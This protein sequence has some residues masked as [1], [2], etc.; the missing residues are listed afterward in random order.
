MDGS[1]AE[2]EVPMDVKEGGVEVLSAM[3]VSAEDQRLMFVKF[4]GMFDQETRRGYMAD[5]NEN[6]DDPELR[7][8]FLQRMTDDLDDH[9]AFIRE[10]GTKALASVDP[11][12]RQKIFV[13]LLSKHTKE[14][15][16]SMILE[17]MTVKNNPDT[18]EEFLQGMY[19]TLMDDDDFIAMEGKKAFTELRILEE[20][21]SAIFAKFMSVTTGE[22]RA[23]YAAGYR[24]AR[25]SPSQKKRFL[26]KLIGLIDADDT[27]DVSFSQELISAFVT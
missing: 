6:K 11:D 13:A 26:E 10:Q 18:K 21:Q 19:E 9:E 5:W 7:V 12:V 17:W 22:D 23:A 2:V 14:E 1:G 15:R 16:E 25:L 20:D 27:T 4:M 8:A 24:S 3:N